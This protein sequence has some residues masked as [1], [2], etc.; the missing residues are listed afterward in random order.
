MGKKNHNKTKNKKNA[1]A[2][3]QNMEIGEEIKNENNIELRDNT[4]SNKDKR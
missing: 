1:K 3:M 2:N 4:K